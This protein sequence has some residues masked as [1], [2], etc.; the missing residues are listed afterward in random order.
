LVRM[1]TDAGYQF[2]L[3][4]AVI[5]ANEQQFERIVAKAEQLIDGSLEGVNVTLLGLTFK[6]HTDDLRNSP[7]IEI[8]NLLIAKGAKLTAYDPMVE[9][10]AGLPEEINLVR[11]TEQAVARSD[12]TLILTEWPEFTRANWGA[13][14]DSMTV[15]RVLDAR[16]ALDRS[17]M[18]ELGFQYDDLG[19]T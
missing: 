8:A 4:R 15:P 5:E 3:L 12:L 9:S 7:A 11:T 10:P 18:V 1:A 6:A 14:R 17:A 13:L 16:N 19:R 2:D